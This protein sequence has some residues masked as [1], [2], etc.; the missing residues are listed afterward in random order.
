M[1]VDVYHKI[2]AN[3]IIHSITVISS[4]TCY[5]ADY[6]WRCMELQLPQQQLNEAI[7]T[8]RPVVT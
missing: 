5:Y 2:I 6:K 3:Y 4:Y 7:I 1:Y 8:F